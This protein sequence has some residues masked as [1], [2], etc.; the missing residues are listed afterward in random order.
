MEI[1]ENAPR[2]EVAHSITI[3]P[4][5]AGQSWQ[6]ITDQIT[7]KADSGVTSG[8]YSL[9]EVTIPPQSE[10]PLHRHNQEDEAYYILEGELLI[11][12]VDETFTAITGSFV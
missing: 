9:F 11:Q 10:L 1:G 7:C 8:G 2:D 4:P 3:I 6:V 12:S 5:G